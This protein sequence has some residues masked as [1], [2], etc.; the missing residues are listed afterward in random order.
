MSAM[1]CQRGHAEKIIDKG[2]DYV[3]AVKV[4]QSS[5]HEA[6]EDYF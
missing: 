4:N 3:L 6:V 1:D 5:L 2:G